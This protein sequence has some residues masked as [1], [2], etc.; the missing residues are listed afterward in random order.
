[1]ADLLADRFVRLSATRT[2]DLASD[3]DIETVVSRAD[4]PAAVWADRCAALAALRHPHILS[5]VDFAEVGGGG[6]SQRLEFYPATSRSRANGPLRAH[7]I[8]S[9]RECLRSSGLTTGPWLAGSLR[10]FDGRLV[11]RPDDGTGWSRAASIAAPCDRSPRER[12]EHQPGRFW[13]VGLRHARVPFLEALTDLLE[14]W[15][16]SLH[17]IR[18]ESLPGAGL[19]TLLATLAIEARVRGFVPVAPDRASIVEALP[20]M[21][22][23]TVVLLVDRSSGRWDEVSPFS[24]LSRWARSG[25]SVA[26]VA[27]HLNASGSRCS[28]SLSRWSPNQLSSLVLR[29]PEALSPGQQASVITAAREADGI[30]G[31]FVTRLASASL[32]CG[33]AGTGDNDASGSLRAAEERSPY[34]SGL[35]SVDLPAAEMASCGEALSL[36]RL[37]TRVDRARSLAACGRRAGPLRV[38]LAAHHAYARRGHRR[39]AAAL[40]R[41][42]GD[43]HLALGDT[44]RAAA[45]YERAAE[46]S[47]AER[48]TASAVAATIALGVTRLE[49][50]QFAL[51]ERLFQSAEAA[52]GAAGALE[53]E[54]YA[55]VELIRCSFWQQRFADVEVRAS[56]LTRV[57]DHAAWRAQAY[58]VLAAIADQEVAWATR[59]MR[60]VTDWRPPTGRA[61]VEWHRAAAIVAARTGLHQ[62]WHA[63]LRDGVTAARA[64]HLPLLAL[65]VRIARFA[66]ARL[67]ASH[68]ES[69]LRTTALDRA[70]RMRLPALLH[71]QLSHALSRSPPRTPVPLAD[72][73]GA[74]LDAICRPQD[75]RR[76][77]TS[78]LL[79]VLRICQDSCDERSAL[80]EVCVLLRRHLGARAVQVVSLEPTV[81]RLA[82]DGRSG[83]DADEAA[84]RAAATCE[85]VGPI[86]GGGSVQA[87]A[88]V[89]IGGST[90]AAVVSSWPIDGC[91]DAERARTLLTGAAAAIAGHVRALA[92]RSALP[93][94]VRE[95]AGDYGLIG[96]SAAMNELRLAVQRAAGA[97]FNVLVEGE[98]GSGKELVARAIHA[99]GPR[100]LG[101]LCAV[102]C[103]ALTEELLEA[104]LFGHARGA[105]TGAVAPRA[106]LFEE[107]DGG[108]LFLDEISELSARGQAKLLRVIQ[109]GEVRRVGENLPRK[110]DVRIVAASNRPLREAA[111]ARRFRQDLLYRLDVLRIVVPP[112]RERLEDVLVLAAHFWRD[113]ASR[114]GSHATLAPATVAAL[115]RYDWPGN[116]RELQNVIAA[117][118]VRAPSRGR[119]GPQCLPEALATAS[120]PPVSSLEEAR[121]GF[122][123]RY[124]RAALAQAGGRRAEA[125]HMLGLT[126]QGL[127]KVML[128]LGIEVDSEG[129][130][131]RSASAESAGELNPPRRV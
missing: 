128:R 19:T 93:Q 123:A 43:L 113:A 55:Q 80:T 7:A 124:V 17:V 104:E 4:V 16:G 109:D 53:L 87:A 3:L 9:A 11:V 129:S 77:M 67:L 52:A 2:I 112:L 68:S 26:L 127:Q 29:Q 74:V 50:A 99:A 92:D 10:A 51:A 20:W 119:V 54:R 79:E 37:R 82:G 59:L 91:A 66:T 94:A 6:R 125:A 120:Q 12:H 83:A 107:A 114:M 130:S 27:G 95:A 21:R 44:T 47:E 65:E 84:R 1:M 48:D 25:P 73:V 96:V 38:F 101:R 22:Q 56:G 60:D 85:F 58:R 122:E 75:G 100:R 126:R 33:G 98:S 18:L 34:D 103:A 42:A 106:G 35:T 90:L 40:A 45:V 97:P 36:S 15:Q 111:T 57:T 46:L 41:A 13:C 28:I 70:R 8:D 69:A 116:V 86:A 32:W 89:R 78:H 23:R 88:P 110:V 31:S 81:A 24:L 118:A 39:E 131:G 14:A 108:T 72:T 105:Y 117:L 5:P 71:A 64:V 61:A 115:A 49:G 30:P 102:N 121:R 62:A 63:H 76:G